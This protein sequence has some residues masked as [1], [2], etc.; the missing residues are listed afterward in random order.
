[1]KNLYTFDAVNEYIRAKLLPLGYEVWTIPGSLIDSYVCIAPD[2]EHYNFVFREE[3]LNEWSSAL[4]CRRC[5][6]LPKWVVTALDK[7]YR[8]EAFEQA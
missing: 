8:E 5:Q 6:R 7:I 2:E 1:M 4:S 3:Y